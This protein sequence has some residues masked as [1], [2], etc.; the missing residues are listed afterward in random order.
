MVEYTAKEGD[1]VTVHRTVVAGENVVAAGSEARKGDVMV[2]R[3][4]RVNHV[5][6][7]IAAAVGRA[8]VAVHRRPR[9]AVLATGDELVDINFV[10]APNEIRNSNSYS[11]AAQVSEAGG[12]A[13]F[14]R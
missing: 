7:A 2:S 6:V 5:A 3:G 1:A 12:E 11:L 13:Q 10:P 14:C 4:A 9:V 8:E